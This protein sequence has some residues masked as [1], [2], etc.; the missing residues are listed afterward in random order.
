[1]KL[2]INLILRENKVLYKNIR[3]ESVNGITD[4][5]SFVGHATPGNNVSVSYSFHS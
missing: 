5:Y 4:L 1:M 3:V 2:G